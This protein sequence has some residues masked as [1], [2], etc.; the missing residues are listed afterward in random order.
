MCHN[1]VQ[2]TLYNDFVLDILIEEHNFTNMQSLFL[3]N[4]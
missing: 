2:Q 1:K 3:Q 4:A